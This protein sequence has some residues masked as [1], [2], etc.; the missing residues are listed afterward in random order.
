MRL[1][2]LREFIIWGL[3]ERDEIER[4]ILATIFSEFKLYTADFFICGKMREKPRLIFFKGIQDFIVYA[5][6]FIFVF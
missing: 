1:K 2:E 3:E 4:N 6:K 5:D